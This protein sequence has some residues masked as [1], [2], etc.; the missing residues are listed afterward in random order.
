[1]ETIHTEFDKEINAYIVNF[2]SRVVL[3]VL[4]LWGSIFSEELE[5]QSGKVGLL[6]NT[7]AHDFDSIECLKWLK[8][9]LTKETVVVSHV[10]RVAFVQPAEYRS[11]EVISKSEAYFANIEDAMEWLN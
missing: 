6:L 11:P 3:D 7:N 5:G 10:S 8:E 9:Y 4:K 2:P 1:M